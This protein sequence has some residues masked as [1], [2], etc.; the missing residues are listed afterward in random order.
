MV[1]LTARLNQIQSRRNSMADLAR[2]DSIFDRLFDF[3]RDFDEIFTHI[4]PASASAGARPP[5]MLVAVPPIEAWVDNQEKKFHLSVALAGVDPKEVQVNVRGNNLT[6]SGEHK[7]EQ[8]KKDRDY[9][10]R[11]FA[12]DRFERTITLPEGLDIEKMTAALNNGVLEITAPLSS[13]ALSRQ[14]EIKTGTSATSAAEAQ[15]TKG[16]TA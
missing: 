2:R 10:Q 11:E 6:V 8:E 13:A 16:A 9:L 15:K 4:L 12:Y 1:Q 3:R 7:T 14:I 5:R